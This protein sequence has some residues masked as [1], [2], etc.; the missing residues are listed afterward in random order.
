MRAVV[1]GGTRETEERTWVILN[2]AQIFFSMDLKLRMSKSLV[3][4]GSK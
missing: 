1:Y 4:I 2:W 3:G